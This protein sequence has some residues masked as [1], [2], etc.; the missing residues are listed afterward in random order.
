M[1]A[2]DLLVFAMTVNSSTT[3]VTKPSG[4]DPASSIDGSGI[5]GRVWTRTATATDA[6]TSV[7]ATTSTTVKSTVSIAAYRSTTGRAQ[8]T[9]A[10]ASGDASTTS[11]TAPSATLT[12]TNSWLVNI[13][14]EKSSVALTWTLPGTTTSRT[15]DGGSGSG[16]TSQVLADS[17]GPLTGPD[18]GTRVATTSETVSK[19]VLFALAITPA[20][21][22]NA[23]PTAAFTYSCTELDCSFNAGT[24][25]DPEAG[26]LTYAWDFGDSATATGVSPVHTY[27]SAGTR[28][29][30][31]TVSDGTNT[32]QATQ[33]VK[34]VVL[35]PPV[36]G[37]GHT[38]L[39]SDTVATTFPRITSGEIYDLEYSGNRVYVAGGFTTIRN[40]AS[41]NTT[42]Y[43]QPYLAAFNLT[44]GLVDASFRPVFDGEVYD[45]E[46]SPDGTKLF[47]AGK[48]N[49]VNGVKKRKFA[50]INPAT[51]ATVT[52]FTAQ[53]DAVGSEV[54]ATNTTVYLGG[55]FTTIN[56]VAKSGLAAVDATTGALVGAT[57]ANPG[58]TWNNDLSGGIGPNGQ[59]TV[60]ELKITPDQ[61][62][63]LVI[64]TGRKVAGETRYGA[65]L[66]NL[67]TGA[68][69]P[70]RTRLWEDNLAFVGG[71]QRAFAADIS[72]DG[73]Y[74]VVTS[75]SG[76]DR[77]PI[78]DTVVRFP[79][80]GEDNVEPTWVARC[81]D[82]VYS[83]AIS[84]K[85]IY[86]GGHFSWNESQTSR[87]PWP[88]LD[89]VGYGTG[90]GLSGY[91]LGDEVVRRDHIGALD[92]A[93]GK[94]VEFN[95]GSDSFEGN[96]AMLVT[97]K[98]L[99]TG[100]DA[101]TQ[102]SQ[103]VG[104][105]AVYSLP[106][107]TAPANEAVIGAPIEGR[108]VESGQPF[109]VSGTA[110]ATSGVS[111]VQIEIRNRDTNAFLA[112][113]L[114]SWV[115][116]NTI[117]ATLASPNAVDTAWSLT[118]TIP[119]TLNLEIRA[120]TFAVNGSSS[121]KVTNKFETFSTSDQSPTATI[122]SPAAG[123]LTSLTFTITGTATDDV[124]VRA[125]GYT[126]RD[127]S[128][129]YLQD[130][131][132]AAAVYNSFTVQPDLVDA[133]T[134]TWSTEVTVPY[135]DTW[136]L[137]VV[138]R[139]TSG[140]SSLD[141]YDRTWIINSSGIAPSVSIVT[142]VVMNPP[143]AVGSVAVTPGSPLSFSGSA[144]DDEDLASVEV[145]LRNN[146]T[147]ETLAA[148]GTWA[149]Q[150]TGW[151]RVTSINL[152]G[153][154][155]TWSYTTPFTLTPG[156][157]SFAVRATDDAGLVTSS[158]NQ[159][160]LTLLA[161]VA[162][163][164]APNG[165]LSVT[166]TVTGLQ[167][168]V[169]NLTGTATDDKGVASV[170]IAALDGDTNRYLQPD[171]SQSAT[172]ATINATLATPN[173]TSTTWSLPLTFPNEGNWQVTAYAYDTAGQQDLS[174]SGATARYPI[175]PGDLPPTVT[176]A[177]A[178]PQAGTVFTDG[179]IVVTGRLEDDRQIATAQVAVVNSVGQYLSSTGTFTSTA[180]SWRTGFLNSPGSAGSN[181]SYT[182]PVIPAGV[183]TVRVRGVDSHGFTTSP[184]YDV[185]NITVQVPA[186]N[187]PVASFTATCGTGADSNVCEFDA[188]A[189]TDEEIGSVTYS[190]NYGTG[191]G[192]A[193][194]V[195]PAAK[196]YTTSGT[197][198]VTLTAK[199]QWNN[200]GT[201]TRTVTITEPTDNVP[202]NAVISE[203]ACSG[204]VCN[205][206]SAASTDPNT[207][208]TISRVWQW[209]DGT[210][211]STSTA[212]SHT[213]ALAGTYTVTLTVTDG[214]GK[215]TT[216]T[217]QLT[218]A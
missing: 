88:G 6:G 150:A 194:G 55:Q 130:D 81:F 36:A 64:H 9:D 193:T 166:G 159:G 19:G 56:G 215:S 110:H 149:V 99:V 74:F 92:P 116:S 180:E 114:T 212:P 111:R 14:G 115:T 153:T 69:L 53:A 25:S 187:P 176:A 54:E 37:P 28:T 178:Q 70:W 173:G 211:Q 2:G 10:R 143:V 18:S 96:K 169:V 129:R 195:V 73:S 165:L 122:T 20:A 41:G 206:S 171:G 90:Q 48:F 168:L 200:V 65:A 34:V 47:V 170:R 209:G 85:A 80:A 162:G 91:G 190:W 58:G 147:G 218:V 132:T 63:L 204:R 123:L 15:T 32:A 154:S 44:T 107:T 199:D 57:A 31:L 217:R 177:L 100:G 75:G 104:R 131:G 94:A 139:D 49:N 35:N 8:V 62:T 103:T 12:G 89:D 155:T 17:A 134:T 208:D 68:L 72:P 135:E 142:P 203:P 3:T 23:A 102:G 118:L 186:S 21:P 145:S 137:Q 27:G 126:L 216:V 144:T 202:P 83:V 136:Q 146:T 175:Y 124:G 51:G 119:A 84:E 151:Y 164:N 24:S 213:F 138:P 101:T 197:F 7:A 5:L 205:F 105:I 158:T 196:T 29:V 76:G 60:Q 210:P 11:H 67:K 121:D 117:N 1:Q 93:L 207:G 113:D 78:N 198:T 66:I 26:A 109:T 4:W 127:S 181:Y 167:S 71:V 156:S 163:D 191:Q 87:D 38:T 125:V 148:D 183:Y 39:V 43:S 201:T 161:Q 45:V 77:P 82:S 157:Y 30:Q 33:S 50:S 52:G 40:N 97:P 214:W 95:P 42:S 13:W 98:G 174:L 192:T 22:V 108:V 128:N 133:A 59:L 79:I 188:R 46:A 120:K 86:I 184:T 140:Q 160:K 172:F 112:D 16:K 106:S 141:T 189:T 185:G 179:K 61:S 152:S 182:T